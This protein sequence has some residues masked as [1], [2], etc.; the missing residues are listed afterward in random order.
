MEN[1]SVVMRALGY[2]WKIGQFAHPILLLLL[3][4]LLLLLLLLLF[5]LL[6][7][8]LLFEESSAARLRRWL[9][10]LTI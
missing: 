3:Y 9:T 7:L 6:L 2:F 8:L 4:L 5:L 10:Y 1:L